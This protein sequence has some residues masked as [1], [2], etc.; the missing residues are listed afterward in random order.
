[1]RQEY[2]S[3]RFTHNLDKNHNNVL[4]FKRDDGKNYHPCQKPLDILE[5]LIRCSSNEDE[6]VLDCFMGSGSTGVACVRTNRNFIGME[7]DEKYIKIAE[8]R[9]AD[10]YKTIQQQRTD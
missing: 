3:L 6:T 10:E 5:R 9:I 1:M 4:R 7:L 2:E 8:K